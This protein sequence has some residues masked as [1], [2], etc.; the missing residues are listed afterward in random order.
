MKQQ[1]ASE[2]IAHINC[3]LPQTLKKSNL[4]GNFSLKHAP[5]SVLLNFLM[6]V[7]LSGF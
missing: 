1:K 4:C 5:V 7:F 6:R 3:A 2:D